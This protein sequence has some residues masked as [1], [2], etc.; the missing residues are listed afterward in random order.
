[1]STPTEVPFIRPSQQVTRGLESTAPA[2]ATPLAGNVRATDLFIRGAV[3]RVTLDEIRK[4]RA[5]FEAVVGRSNFL[6][7]SF[8][9]IGAASARATCLV[10]AAGNDF[11]GRA[12]SWTGT[13]FL[14]GPSLLL[15]NNHVLNSVT[16]ATSATAVFDFQTGPDGR[17]L[18]PS[19]FNLRPE[20]LF[21]TSPITGG[22]DYTICWVD[23]EPGQ[24]FGTVRVRR[25]AFGIAV[26]EFAN[27]VSHPAGRFK[28]VV[29]QENNVSWQDDLVVHYTSDTEP[30][31]SGAAVCNNS[32]QLVALHHASKFVEGGVINEGIKISAI[33]GDLERLASG[34]AAAATE[35][36]AQFEGSDERLGFFGR[37]GR[38]VPA[39]DGLE[40]VVNTFRGTENDIDVGFWNVEWL[41]KYYD[42][43]TPAVARVIHELNLDVWSIEESSPNAAEAVVT[44]LKE[45]Y[46]LDYRYLAAEPDTPDGKQSCTV[47]WNAKTVSVVEEDWGEPIET[48]LSAHSRDFADLGLGGF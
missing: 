1:M 8:L 3:S 21:L 41:T 47:L 37:L 17:P 42:T 9:E 14:I 36:L 32:W 4:G 33:A 46:E 22:L 30:G 6:P 12:G 27:V 23:G 40:A 38:P 18:T 28:E 39:G 11:L 10:R 15:T 44:E 2:G 48:W 20:R 35:V 29:L 5:G 25:T 34:G 19:V 26:G 24:R 7:A 31:S 13:G 43:K 16:V 45:A